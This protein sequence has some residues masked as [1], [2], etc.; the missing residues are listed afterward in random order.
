MDAEE[1]VPT[2]PVYSAPPL[3]DISQYQG[4]G[5]PWEESWKKSTEVIMRNES[6]RQISVSNPQVVGTNIVTK[7]VCYTVET[8]PFDYA[9][10][11]RY[12][13]FIWLR[14]RLV[15]SFPGMLVP[16]LPP[17]KSTTGVHRDIEGDFIR[18]RM[19]HL[20]IWLGHLSKIPFVTGD[21]AL[22]AFLTKAAGPEW[23]N[24][25]KSI[26]SGADVVTSTG[27][28]EWN[29]M[30]DDC[31]SPDDDVT[32]ERIC[33]ETK[34]HLSIL[35]SNLCEA[36]QAWSRTANPLV[37]AMKELALLENSVEQWKTFEISLAEPTGD[38]ANIISGMGPEM[39]AGAN[40]FSLS[41]GQ[42]AIESKRFT[43][44]LFTDMLSVVQY[45]TMLAEG[46][47]Q[48]MQTRDDTNAAINSLERE[49]GQLRLEKDRLSRGSLS[50]FDKMQ[51]KSA[52]KTEGSIFRR[53]DKLE[54]MR[55]DATRIGR[56]L[57]FCEVDRY[58]KER[59][60]NLY[61]YVTKMTEANVQAAKENLN[62]WNQIQNDLPKL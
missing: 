58:S 23:D 34:T 52:D 12:N 26:E 57:W 53:E 1:I 7:Y 30:L 4:M 15:S 5:K 42:V 55:A 31:N 20:H 35:V 36:D 21:P 18:T 61:A 59:T 29:A 60:L 27:N 62:A 9:V 28:N 54:K 10:Q 22:E 43:D 25:K 56:A 13:D 38:V 45:Q 6:Q 8:Q 47:K 41:I 16:A 46:L 17:K 11:R 44:S 51:G 50:V 48:L 49:L 2:I 24:A 37:N 33:V 39:K 40:A 14:D 3:P 32:V 19:N